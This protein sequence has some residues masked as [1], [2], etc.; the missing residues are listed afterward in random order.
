MGST[1]ILPR[2]PGSCPNP[3]P[4]LLPRVGGQY[5][6]GVG[7]RV[8]AQPGFQQA[9]VNGSSGNARESTQESD[10]SQGGLAC[11]PKIVAGALAPE[12]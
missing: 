4:S 10:W 2:V 6:L 12:N 8:F 11:L 9:T 1:S 5:P 7:G 3:S